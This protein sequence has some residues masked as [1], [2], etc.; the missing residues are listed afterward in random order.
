MG[1][2][3]RYANNLILLANGVNSCMVFFFLKKKAAQLGGGEEG[4]GKIG[5][6]L[7]AGG[8]FQGE[9]SLK[10]KLSFRTKNNLISE[11]G[12]FDVKILSHTNPHARKLSLLQT[13]HYHACLLRSG[14]STKWASL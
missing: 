10:Q 2:T 6:L 7:D 12:N 14:P 5:R 4:A 1:E 13:I 9:I 11:R 3:N 8:L